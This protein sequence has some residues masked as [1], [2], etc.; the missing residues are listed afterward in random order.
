[1]R[2]S[3]ENKLYIKQI[4]DRDTSEL[5]KVIQASQELFGLQDRPS[6]ELAYANLVTATTA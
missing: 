2:D 5:E 3:E 4:Q 1:M 6:L